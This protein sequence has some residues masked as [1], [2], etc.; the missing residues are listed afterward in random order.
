[1]DYPAQR[2]ER[3]SQL[4]TDENLD[5]F[6]ITN[7]VNVTYLTGFSG[8]SS[9]LLLDRKRAILVSDPRYTQQIAEE[10]RGVE[11][12]IRTPAQ[13]IYEA[14][15]DLLRQLGWRSVGFE[16]SLPF[17]DVETLKQAT[18]AINWKGA[19]E[20]V[21]RLRMVKD[22]WE[23][24][25]IREAIDIA[26][27]SFGAF[28]MML[29]PEDT[30]RELANRMEGLVR[31]CGGRGTCFPTIIA[32]A[33]RAALPH[34][35]PTKRVA[36]NGEL[37]LVDWGADGPLAYKS[38]LTRV[39]TARKISAKLKALY[40]VVLD[41]QRAAIR[42]VRPGVQGQAIDA[43]ARA[44][45]AAA[46]FGDFFGHGLGHGIG[47]QVHEGPA[48]RPKS[49]VVVEAGM[50]FTIEPGVY[51]PDWGGIRIEDDVL[52]TPDGCEVLTHVPRELEAMATFG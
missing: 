1:M 35:I 31:H 18:P 4:L 17:G 40:A 43:E 33:E 3:L 41:A 10:C 6:L 8:D 28:R 32:A 36:V 9:V 25:Q 20:R 24:G 29:R 45:I 39:L 30:E 23:L 12:R 15:A 48:I 5:G 2:R 19:A 44:V 50:V 52:V 11:I 37:L 42:V 49:D 46:G 21:E 51:L 13:K 26:E 34:A 47:L 16:H 27:R 7:A 38:D 22:E 14:V